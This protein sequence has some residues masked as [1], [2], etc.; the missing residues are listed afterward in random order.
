M[1]KLLTEIP[2]NLNNNCPEKAKTN[3]VINAAIIAFLAVLRWCFASKLEVIVINTG[4]T[5]NGFI[6]EKKEVK[7]NKPKAI[8]SVMFGVFGNLIEKLHQCK[9]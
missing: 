5:P 6:N 4:I 8:F 7:H 9:R 2:K 3:N 1:R